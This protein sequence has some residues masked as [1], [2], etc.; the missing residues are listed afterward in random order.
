ML[1]TCTRYYTRGCTVE[2]TAP[3]PCTH[4]FHQI[5]WYGIVS[6]HLWYCG[7]R[8][9]FTPATSLKPSRTPTSTRQILV[10]DQELY[11]PPC[12]HDVMS[13]YLCYQLFPCQRIQ[14]Y[15][16]NTVVQCRVIPLAFKASFRSLFHSNRVFHQTVPLGVVGGL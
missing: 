3:I 4:P 5:S 2:S 16:V 1:P 15:S 12:G 13:M 7:R 10:C 14:F 11:N 6:L 8:S 9:K